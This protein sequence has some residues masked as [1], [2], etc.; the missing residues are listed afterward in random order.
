[1]NEKHQ[2]K[3][4]WWEL[5]RDIVK[6]KYHKGEPLETITGVK[7]KILEVGE[8]YFVVK[9]ER[10]KK[11]RKITKERVERVLQ[12]VLKEG[13]YSVHPKTE[14]M[15]P[16]LRNLNDGSNLRGGAHTSIIRGLLINLP[17]IIEGGRA[18]KIVFS[19]V[20]YDKAKWGIRHRQKEET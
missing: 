1:M 4:R 13:Y 20:N 14:D 5:L 7:N 8:D 11:N 3:E 6:E 17:F 2:K 10:G 16:A 18:T 9:S 19:P 12:M 15:S